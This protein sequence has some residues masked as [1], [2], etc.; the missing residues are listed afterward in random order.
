LRKYVFIVLSV[1]LLLAFATLVYA[2]EPQI[3]LGGNIMVRGWYIHNA[4]FSPFSAYNVTNP[5]NAVPG[6]IKTTSAIR[7]VPITREAE[8]AALWTSDISLTLDAKVSDN[9]Q[10]FIELEIAQGEI[11]VERMDPIYIAGNPQSGSYM[12]GNY[13]SKPNA[14]LKLRQ[15]WIQ[16]T[17]S[18]LF[19]VPS[20]MKIGH[21]LL[22][23]GEKQFLNHERFGDDALVVF[24]NPTKE[25]SLAAATAKLNEGYYTVPGDDIDVYAL[26]GAYK[27]DKDN[28]IG[29]YYTYF[30]CDDLT[31]A[32]GGAYGN[33]PGSERNGLSFQDLGAHAHGL[34]SGMISYA[35]ELDAQF[36]KA[37]VQP[38]AIGTPPSNNISTEDIKYS[39]YAVYLKG[40]YKI[41]DSPVNLRASF[42][43]GSGDQNALDDNKIKEFQVTEG[44]D[45]ETNIDR[46]VHYTQIYE[47]TIATSA[48]MQTLG[49]NGNIIASSLDPHRNTGIANTTYYNLGIDLAA[50]KDLSM[51]L[52]GYILRA[53]KVGGW[54]TVLADPVTGEKPS[55]SKSVGWEADFTGTYKLSKNLNYFVEA[56]YFSP[57]SFYQDTGMV[58]DRN[59]V[60]QLIHG[61]NLSF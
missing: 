37:D 7:G 15:A 53:S 18:G 6:D 56:G 32:F 36:G 21:Q 47:R 8:D 30:D 57:G 14:D 46:F 19:G 5:T 28:T 50:T 55:V 2:E 54:E 25:L 1:F 41:P 59:S 10:G 42:A 11:A 58:D 39:G 60:T 13:E 43:Y 49:G 27:V 20:G 31:E 23:L 12:W 45:T 51:S 35:L 44:F 29:L 34:L 9:V 24:V 48:L 61:L 38:G 33:P 22:T 52:D 17:G 4:N 16:Y 3:K 40:G 26:I